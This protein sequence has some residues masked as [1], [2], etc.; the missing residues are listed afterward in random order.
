MAVEKLSS[1]G[2]P[3]KAKSKRAVIYTRVFTIDQ[4][5]ETQLYDLRE[6]AKQ[7]GYEIVGKYSDKISGSKQK[8][9]GLDQLMAMPD[10]TNSIPCSSGLSIGWLDQSGTFSKSLMSSI[11]WASSSLASART[12][13]LEVHLV[14]Q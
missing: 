10:G 5:P 8:R 1:V 9:P 13:T 12:S 11:T 14:G 4:H 2:I 6:M 3:S 7:R